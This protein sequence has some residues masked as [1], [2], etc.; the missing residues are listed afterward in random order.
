MLENL[1]LFHSVKW[2]AFH[3][4]NFTSGNKELCFNQTVSGL[5]NAFLPWQIK[6]YMG[7]IFYIAN[8]KLWQKKLQK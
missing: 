6:I 3:H 8:K 2:D 1:C 4:P 7:R 5:T